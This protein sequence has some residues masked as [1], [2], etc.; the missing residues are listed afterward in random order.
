M[1]NFFSS[2]EKY[3]QEFLNFSCYNFQIFL[4]IHL[5][6]L[7]TCLSIIT[8]SFSGGGILFLI[9]PSIYGQFLSYRRSLSM[10]IG[11]VIY[12]KL[13]SQFRTR[14]Q[15]NAEILR[16]TYF[17]DI[18]SPNYWIPD[19]TTTFFHLNMYECI[20]CMRENEC[21]KWAKQ[22]NIWRCACRC[23]HCILCNLNTMQYSMSKK[24]H[25]K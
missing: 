6:A 14:C 19:C 7:H 15:K 21:K 22:D 13:V 8:P 1:D 24:F 4:V 12:P 20:L 23:W 10:V 3:F 16:L 11:K 9:S 18:L 2:E 17:R 5:E 25:K